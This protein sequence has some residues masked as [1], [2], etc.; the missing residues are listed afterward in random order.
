MRKTLRS[1]DIAIEYSWYEWIDV[2]KIHLVAGLAPMIIM[3]WATSHSWVAQFIPHQM[4]KNLALENVIFIAWW[5]DL[6]MI[7]C[8]LQMCNIDMATLFLILVS[9]IMS[10]VFWFVRESS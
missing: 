2:S 9:D 1:F 10:M 4:A 6:A 8:P 5:I 3:M 7:S